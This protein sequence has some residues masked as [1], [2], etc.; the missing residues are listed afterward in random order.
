MEGE[1][2]ANRMTHLEPLV[3][4]ILDALPHLKPGQLLRI[5]G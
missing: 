4:T 2:D 1:Y 5:G 3:P